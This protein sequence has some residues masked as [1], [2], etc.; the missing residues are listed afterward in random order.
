MT[1]PPVTLGI[2]GGE[3]KAAFPP[4]L[5]AVK[6]IVN[7]LESDDQFQPWSIMIKHASILDSQHRN[8]GYLSL[9]HKAYLGL[10]FSFL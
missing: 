3:N 9:S 8:G 10:A 1:N 4:K 5:T 6:A 2:R 7:L